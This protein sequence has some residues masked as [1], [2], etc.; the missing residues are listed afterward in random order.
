MELFNRN[1]KMT[2]L[3]HRNYLLLPVLNRFGVRLG[4]QDKTVSDICEDAMRFR[5]GQ[6]I[7][8][9]RSQS[10]MTMGKGYYVQNVD[11]GAVDTPRIINDK[12]ELQWINGEWCEVIEDGY[13]Y[14]EDGDEIKVGDEYFKRGR[15]GLGFSHNRWSHFNEIDKCYEIGNKWKN[16]E[17]LPFRRR[18]N[19]IVT[20]I[21]CDV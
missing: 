16:S 9:M 19:R 14:L 8:T 12:G 4:F 5:Q 6:M 21:G 7:Q 20:F 1:S 15:F 2:D 17:H 18:K 11:P 10:F 13:H 3:V